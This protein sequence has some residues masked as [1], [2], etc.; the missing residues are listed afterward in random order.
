MY[1]LANIFIIKNGL[2]AKKP[3]IELHVPQTL[4]NRIK[5]T[6]TSIVHL[7]SER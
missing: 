2:K 4:Q 5:G 3:K 7:K 1:Q 6:S